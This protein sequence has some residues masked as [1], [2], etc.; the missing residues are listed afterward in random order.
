MILGVGSRVEYWD[1]NVGNAAIARP[2]FRKLRDRFPD[3]EIKTTLPF[4]SDLPDEY[5]LK[6]IDPIKIPKLPDAPSNEFVQKD[7]EPK[8]ADLIDSVP[9]ESD[10]YKQLQ[11]SDLVLAFNCDTFPR[12]SS[13]NN[14]LPYVIDICIAAQSDCRIVDIAGSPGP[15]S[16]TTEKLLGRT[17]YSRIDGVS[18]R[19]DVSYR[20][21]Q[22]FNPDAE[23]VKAACPAF[24]LEPA[25][26][27]TAERILRQEGVSFDANMLIG[28]NMCRFNR[29]DMQ[30]NETQALTLEDM[31]PTLH[32]L[33]D[34]FD[35]ELVLIPHDYKIDTSGAQTGED[36]EIL[37]SY[38]DYL[39]DAG[40]GS[41][42]NLLDS[43]YTAPELKGV[44]GQLDFF[45][46][47]RLHAGAAGY[48]QAVPTLLLAYAHK[49]R[50]FAEH[51]FQ[52]DGVVEN[53]DRDHLLAVTKHLCQNIEYRNRVLNQRHR[54]VKQRVDINFDLIEK[55]S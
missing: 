46:S 43:I 12:Y 21:L 34:E 8:I 28:L 38:L 13:I 6:T 41:R 35:S 17:V 15:F 31:K 3:A 4:F 30:D 39:S 5:D 42:V 36:R 53:F 54:H 2:F 49:H 16:T 20:Y 44:V 45:V 23:V 52:Q 50:G 29:V 37:Q 32:Y 47:G 22:D 48:S 1:Q 26:D 18:T 19:E 14:I 25:G 10:E 7:I 9:N 27:D 24:C 51:Y 40:Y 55:Y 33:L 11:D